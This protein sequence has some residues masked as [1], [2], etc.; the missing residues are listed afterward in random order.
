MAFKPHDAPAAAGRHIQKGLP[1]KLKRI[2]AI[3]GII[4]LAGM[5]VLTLIF[6]LIDSPLKNSLLYAS[7]YCT[8]IIPVLIY[9]FL[10]LIRLFGKK[11]G[12]SKS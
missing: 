5:Y 11:G 7:L 8:V 10:L 2:L 9:V 12:D 1:M 4:I 3:V 6:A